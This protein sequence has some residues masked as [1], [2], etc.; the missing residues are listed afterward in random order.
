MMAQG[1]PIVATD[2]G[3]IAN[4]L[5]T[6]EDAAGIVVPLADGRVDRQRFEEALRYLADDAIRAGYGRAARKRYE[7]H[8]TTDA[9]ISNYA[10]LYRR[11]SSHEEKEAQACD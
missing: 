3:E 2:V 1:K 8:F 10:A 9:M 7:A 11:L 4:M 5:G 6:G